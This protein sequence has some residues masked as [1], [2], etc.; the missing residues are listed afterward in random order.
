MIAAF[1][2]LVFLTAL[3]MLVVVGARVLEENGSKI[4]AA[5]KGQSIAPTLTTSPI[6]LR[7]RHREL[8]AYRYNPRLR[9]SA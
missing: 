4:A 8:G 9:A 1:A 3:W 2:T 6:R 5:L 7:L